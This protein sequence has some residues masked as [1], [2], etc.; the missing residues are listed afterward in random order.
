MR[1]KIAL[2]L[3]F[4]ISASAFSAFSADA[5]G[6]KKVKKVKQTFAT[7]TSITLKWSKISRAKYEVKICSEKKAKRTYRN[8]KK[9]TYKLSKL[10]AGKTY[11]VKVR[12]KRYGVYGAWSKVYK[13]FTAPNIYYKWDNGKLKVNWTKMKRASSYNVKLELNSNKKKNKRFKNIKGTSCTFTKNQLPGLSINKVYNISVLPYSGKNK[14]RSN[15]KLTRD[16]E[17]IGHRGRMD[18]A[19]ENTLAS[20]KEA[21]KSHYDSFEAD[22]WETYSGEILICHD[23]ILTAC[24]SKADIRTVTHNS[25]KRYP[26]KKGKN[27]KSYSTQYLPT[28]DQVIR[29]AASYKMKLYLHLKDPKTSDKGLKKIAAAIKKY[30]ME[31]KVT[32]FSSNKTAFERIVKNKIQSGYLKLPK[33][34][35][36]AKEI[37]K[38]AKGKTAKFVI[39]KFGSYIT[40]DLI[41]YARSIKIR[42][43]C[44]NVSDTKTGSI[45]SNLGGDFL[46]TNNYY[47]N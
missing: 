22:F 47:F 19:P 40:P 3:A 33:N 28:V 46:I 21:Y 41:K 32:V 6:V 43:G 31:G 13:F 27:V 23:S 25:I 16:I 34:V 11:A 20:F 30:K 24:G 14:L 39:F 29:D 45:F 26:I 5:R 7:A 2:I 10:Q 38:Y 18:I 12:A 8:I 1:K 35:S 37:L 42:L 9:N 17:V 15:K 44:Y 36:D 4:I